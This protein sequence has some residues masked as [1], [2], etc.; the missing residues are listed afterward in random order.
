[1]FSVYT[2]L[3]KKKMLPSETGP[4][5][6][7]AKA[8]LNKEVFHRCVQNSMLAPVYHRHSPIHNCRMHQPIRHPTVSCKAQKIL[9]IAITMLA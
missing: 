6:H 3:L 2:I 5:N 8:L 1:M 9:I 7:F 4:L